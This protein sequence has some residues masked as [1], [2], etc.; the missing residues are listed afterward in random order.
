[1]KR[2]ALSVCLLEHSCPVVP[3]LAT[4]LFSCLS[5]FIKIKMALTIRGPSLDDAWFDEAPFRFKHSF[6]NS[7]RYQFPETPE[8]CSLFRILSVIYRRLGQNSAELLVRNNTILNRFL[9][10]FKMLIGFSR[11]DCF[12]SLFVLFL[13]SV[14][15]LVTLFIMLSSRGHHLPEL[16]IE[17]YAPPLVGA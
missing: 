2:Q 8:S 7:A 6:H 5:V 12:L 16:P 14:S 11:Q 13:K 15:L 17:Q 9:Y 1:V 4:G 10:H 3:L